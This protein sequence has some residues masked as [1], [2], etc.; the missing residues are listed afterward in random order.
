MSAAVDRFHHTQSM[1]SGWSGVH[2]IQGVGISMQAWARS[3]CRE[4][5][6][7]VLGSWPMWA[8]SCEFPSV[9]WA[10]MDL[11][12]SDA[13]VIPEAAWRAPG[14]DLYG[15]DRAVSTLC[16]R[17]AWLVVLGEEGSATLGDTA[18]EILTRYQRIVPRTNDASGT[19]VFQTV[20]SGHHALH[21]LSLP[22]VRADYDH[23]VDVWQWTLRLAPDASL[24]L[25]LGA[26][27]HDVERLLSESERRIEQ[28]APD[29]QAFKN[30]HADAGARL[31]GQVL[32]RCGVER[33][34]IERVAQLIRAHEL[35]GQGAVGGDPALLADADALSFFSLNSPGFADYYGPEHTRKKVRYTLGRMSA[36]AVQRLA[37][38]RLRDDVRQALAATAREEAGVALGRGLA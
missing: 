33:A 18:R 35:P 21:D 2:P 11:P 26:L 29:Y 22:L 37:G 15:W 36:D 31:A 32:E 4:E 24:E 20:L 27:F 16:D 3:C 17:P 10:L 7:A 6:A 23:A 19:S 34:V 5:A 9:T 1:E 12:P 13:L 28:H 25:Q 38:I 14:S 8:L 30:A